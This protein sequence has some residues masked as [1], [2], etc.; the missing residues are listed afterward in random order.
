[1]AECIPR[2]GRRKPAGHG[3]AEDLATERGHDDFMAQ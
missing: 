1:M 2:I 3:Q